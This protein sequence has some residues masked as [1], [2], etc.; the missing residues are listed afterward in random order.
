M[1]ISSSSIHQET[2]SLA[3]IPTQGHQGYSVAGG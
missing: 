3:R 2:M 1:D